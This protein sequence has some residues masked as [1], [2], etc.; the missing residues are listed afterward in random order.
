MKVLMLSWEF[1]PNV[2][3]GLGKA[4]T[5]LVPAIVA[6]GTE[7]H[8]ITPLVGDS[9]ETEML[10]SGP[11]QLGSLTIHRVRPPAAAFQDIYTLAEE[12]NRALEAHARELIETEHFDLI[13]VH[14]W[15]AA[16]A[17]IALKH[18]HHLPL[19]S[20]IHA[21]EYGRH[22]GHI[23]TDMSRAIHNLEWWLTYESWRVICC[24]QFMTT[25]L[26]AAFRTPLD[27]VDVIANGIDSAPFDALEGADLTEFR[28]QFA[29]PDEQ[30]IFC[31]GRVVHEKG[32]S[33]LVEALPRMLSRYPKAKLVIT[34]DGPNLPAVRTRAAELGVANRVY[35]T[36][37]V[38]S[39]DRN[40]LYK[41]ANVAVFPSLYEPFGIVALEAMVARVP[42]VASNVG[43]IAEVV[44]H[45]ETGLLVYPNNPE[46][47]A[48]G[49]LETLEHPD[50]AQQRVEKAYRIAVAEY[51]WRAIARQTIAVYE[52]V[53][54]E[55]AAAAW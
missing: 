54:Q 48:W 2:V 22:R 21:T 34:G 44:D 11:D 32:A 25:E 37:F 30:I 4:V 43:G 46:S 55:R 16:F 24:S 35:F 31:I 36:G 47:L 12:T 27:K 7:I 10:P 19:V 26:T 18:A 33:V 40:R 20:T 6:E 13:H 28:S 1:R 14:D 17:G 5:E 23:Y 29:A 45:N 50:W 8:L 41:L 38:S 49:I 9:P 51:N 42:V 15:L 39:G 53:I 3:G 52:Q